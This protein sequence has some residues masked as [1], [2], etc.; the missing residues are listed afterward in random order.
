M[1]LHAYLGVQPVPFGN[2]EE[3]GLLSVE[4][5][6]DYLVQR[7]VFSRTG[8][9]TVGQLGGGISNVVLAATQGDLSVVVKQALEK[10][11]VA[12]LWPASRE[13]TITEAEAL[14]LAQRLSPGS[15]PEVLDLDRQACA[16]TILAAPGGWENWKQRLLAGDADPAIAEDLGRLL[17]KWQ[18][19]TS[20][21]AAVARAFGSTQVFYQLRVDPYYITVAK[22]RP[23]L[24]A[25]IEDLVARMQGTRLCLVHGDYSPKNVLVGQGRW[26]IDFEVA[27]YGDPSFDIAFMVNHLLLKRLHVPTAAAD[28]ALCAKAFWR[29]FE[30]VLVPLAIRPTYVF[31]HVGCLMVAR[32]DGKSPVEY[33][34]Q[35]E[36]EI[37]RRIGS[38]FLLDPPAS[39]EEALELSDP[40]SWQEV[41]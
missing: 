1:L 40:S 19:A 26:V 6:G 35:A 14:R 10:L 31:G 25:A 2:H 3:P 16:L 38:Q 9:I 27:H 5:V 17:A 34:G 29:A 24:Q 41:L 4:T 13:R 30:S 15:V 33:L 18:G 12:D 23:E 7:G 37:A 21:D 32:V 28:L 8:P 39:M 11:R 20:G 36:R 22:R